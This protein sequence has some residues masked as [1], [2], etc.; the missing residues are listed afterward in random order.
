M[1]WPTTWSTRDSTQ[2]T[3]AKT[4]VEW[5][6]D[7]TAAHGYANLA[8]VNASWGT[9]YGSYAAIPE[10]SGTELPSLTLAST[11]RAIDVVLYIGYL[12]D[13]LAA[14]FD[15]E[16][17]SFGYTGLYCSIIAFP[18]SVFMRDSAKA[19]ANDVVNLHNYTFLAATPDKC[20][21]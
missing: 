18:N 13:Q 19:G 4:W 11:Q 21:S 1:A 2:G 17:T 7:T 15:T 5:L 20:F 12:D 14:Y 9:A 8:A 16:M 10:P 6:Q 3:G